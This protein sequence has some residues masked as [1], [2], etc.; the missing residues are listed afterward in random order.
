MRKKII[1]EIRE[2]EEEKSLILYNQLESNAPLEKD[3]IEHDKD[4]FK[5]FISNLEIGKEAEI[6]EINIFGRNDL[7]HCSGFT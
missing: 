7:P 4:I 5:K 1:E 6:M 3:K 2:M